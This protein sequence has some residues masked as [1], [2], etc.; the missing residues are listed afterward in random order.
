[1]LS[2]LTLQFG[3]L[4]HEPS[5]DTALGR[6]RLE[7]I[8]ASR[9]AVKRLNPVKLPYFAIKLLSVVPLVQSKLGR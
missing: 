5:N 6:I 9:V 2:S 3:S 8:L 4:K 7:I 1:V